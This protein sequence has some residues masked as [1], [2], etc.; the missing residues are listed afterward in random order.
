MPVRADVSGLQRVTTKPT[1]LNSALI[2]ERTEFN[3]EGRNIYITVVTA[4]AHSTPA[5]PYANN[6]SR[7]PY[8]MLGEMLPGKYSVFYRGPGE[9][10]VDLG[11]VSLGEDGHVDA[12]TSAKVIRHADKI[13]VYAGMWTNSK[14]LFSSTSVKDIADFNDAIS[15]VPP[16]P[17]KEGPA[18]ACDPFPDGPTVR[19]YR[20]GTELVLVTNVNKSPVGHSR[21]GRRA[22]LIRIDR[23]K[24]L[25]WFGARKIPA[26]LNER[27]AYEAGRGRSENGAEDR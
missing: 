27:E 7:C 18:C 20:G 22:V 2:C 5:L 25:K 13:V 6:S 10:P 17:P 23:E 16:P 15:V 8:I 24:W 12:A 3:V 14:V 9:A 26:P 21:W 19:L 4:P 11:E 1:T